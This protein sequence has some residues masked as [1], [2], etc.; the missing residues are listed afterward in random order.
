MKNIKN[1][2]IAVV[3]IA[4]ACIGIVA[5][6]NYYNNGRTKEKKV[7]VS[8]NEQG[9]N[10][11]SET[12]EG[13][14]T[15]SD[16]ESEEDSEAEVSGEPVK[17]T[18]L[19]FA[20]GLDIETN[21]GFLSDNIMEILGSKMPEDFNVIMMT[22]GTRV[23]HMNLKHKKYVVD[24]NGNRV[25]MVPD[26]KQ[27]WKLTGSEDGKPGKLIL[28]E[29][30]KD[31][32][33]KAY[34]NPLCLQRL[35]DYGV[36]NYPA[37]KYD[38]TFWSHGFSVLG[39]CGDELCPEEK[40]AGKTLTMRDMIKAFDDSKLEEKFEIINFD[41]C[42]M[43]SVEAISA[44]SD[45]TDY[46]IGSAE[47]IP[48]PS[49]PY[50]PWIEATEEDPTLQGFELG[51]VIVDSYKEYY[52]EE[53]N[54]FSHYNATLS[55]T[56]TKKFVER[57]TPVLKEFLDIMIKEAV[58]KGDNGRFNY[59]DEIL[60]AKLSTNY[61]DLLGSVDLGNLAETIGVCLTERDNISDEEKEML[62]NNYTEI[63][64]KIL[65]VINDPE[66]RYYKNNNTFSHKVE[67]HISRDEEG[68]VVSDD[69]LEPYGLAIFLPFIM[70][71]TYFSEYMTT[72]DEL[73]E[74]Y[75][76]NADL[77]DLFKKFK[78]NASLY[79]SIYRCGF[80]I[81]TLATKDKYDPS[82]EK[83]VKNAILDEN[84]DSEWLEQIVAQQEAEVI[85]GDSQTFQVDENA[86]DGKML[87][88]SDTASMR[89]IDIYTPFYQ[90]YITKVKD[91]FN[92]NETL[93][94][95]KDGVFTVVLGQED[96]EMNPDLIDDTQDNLLFERAA[97]FEND[98][99]S[100]ICK[101]YD[102]KW[103]QLTDAKGKTHLVSYKKVKGEDDL[104][105]IPITSY[106]VVNEGEK[107]S[108]PEKEHM[109]LTVKVNEDG[110]YEITNK[111]KLDLWGTVDFKWNVRK[112][113][114]FKG[115]YM[116]FGRNYN[117]NLFRLNKNAPVELDFDKDDLGVSIQGNVDMKDI[118]DVTKSQ[119]E[120]LEQR[121]Y[122]KDI[123]GVDHL[124]CTVK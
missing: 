14:E 105:N 26:K 59:Y 93:E 87:V 71:E 25:E 124:V 30:C 74:I 78:E 46:Y 4:I 12:D 122:V 107:N 70:D 37:D 106:K 21:N 28:L 97:L 94:G 5:G 42:L 3:I 17:R 109:Q 90:Q 89:N 13:K 62:I 18:L 51:K 83:V 85:K 79:N 24:E 50:K 102:E 114:G 11:S 103:I 39:C 2:V 60:S 63:S 66:V 92:K 40:Y 117:L 99:V 112:K 53:D 61:Q 29:E 121:I 72:F 88:S 35:I 41:C 9:A 45:Y 65:D 104:I 58:E 27:I 68:N 95:Y 100:F 48:A 81:S 49:E 77:C 16:K 115:F 33:D 91:D 123:Y 56:D 8:E 101:D 10:S 96:C 57:M 44:L 38:L 6:V 82:F 80:K 31:L 52:D 73:I 75:Q 20:C 54:A 86:G 118:D 67:V 116:A 47:T 110:T 22:G 43:A 1:A 32:E 7:E 19:L 36:E 120:Q 119:I 34:V 98:G 23:Y 108:Y 113:P 76:D 55:V 69:I 111:E 84:Y 15:E 64:K